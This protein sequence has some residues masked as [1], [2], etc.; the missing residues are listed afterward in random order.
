V[1]YVVDR[2][3]AESLGTANIHHIELGLEDGSTETMKPGRPAV[4]GAED[5]VIRKKFSTFMSNSKGNV[6]TEQFSKW[7]TKRNLSESQVEMLRVMMK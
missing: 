2:E 6:S 3:Q 1:V 7:C 5:K 4:F